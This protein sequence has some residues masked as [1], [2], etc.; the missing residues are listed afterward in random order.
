MHHLKPGRLE[1]EVAGDIARFRALAELAS[2][3]SKRHGS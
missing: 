3:R 1:T 2:K